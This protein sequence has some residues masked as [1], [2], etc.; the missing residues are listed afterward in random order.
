MKAIWAGGA[1]IAALVLG[2]CII[3]ATDADWDDDDHYDRYSGVRLL[4]ADVAGDDIVLRVASNGCTTKEFFD[5]DI[6]RRGERRFKV[7]LMRERTDNCDT[8]DPAG[9]ALVYT[10]AELGLPADARISIGNRIGE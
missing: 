4:A 5:V 2:G 9:V 3:V 6:D 10:R 8:P 7:T 1:A